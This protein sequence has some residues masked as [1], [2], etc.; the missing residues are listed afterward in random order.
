M[1][2]NE[3]ANL[4]YGP[5]HD[6]GESG[7]AEPEPTWREQTAAVLFGPQSAGDERDDDH[8]P[9]DRRAL[10][11]REETARLLFGGTL[12]KQLDGILLPAFDALGMNDE[13]RGTLRDDLLDIHENTGLGDVFVTRLADA[14]VA[15]EIAATRASDPDSRGEA[16]CE[17]IRK[18]NESIRE[19]LRLRH[20]AAEAERLLGRAQAFARSH[21]ALQRFLQSHGIGSRPEI[22]NEIIHHVVSTGWR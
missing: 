10:S 11:A 16:L 15:A 9:A 22:V 8:G 12:G 19:D 21:P 14:Y 17:E 2:T 3:T 18:N 5:R 13:S 20:G 1:D 6:N 4:L 7:P